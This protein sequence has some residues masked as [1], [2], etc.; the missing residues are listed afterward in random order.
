MKNV[1]V[2]KKPSMMVVDLR[3]EQAVAASDGNCMPKASRDN[4][5]SY[6]FYY[7]VE[8]VGW[9]EIVTGNNCSGSYELVYK[10]YEGAAGQATEAAKEAAEE[11]IKTQMNNDKQAFSGAYTEVQPTWS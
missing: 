2:Y 4:S 7:D 9:Y 3:S 11:A 1:N 8:G 6:T 5:G 10:T